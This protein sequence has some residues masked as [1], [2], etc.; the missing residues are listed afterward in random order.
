MPFLGAV[1]TCDYV[2]DS[3]YDFLQK[4]V[5]N[6]ICDHF[7]RKYVDKRCVRRIIKTL[8]TLYANRARNRR[9]V[10]RIARTRTPLGP[11]STYDL[12][13][14]SAF[15]LQYDLKQIAESSDSLSDTHCNLQ[16]KT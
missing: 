10:P 9:L 6:Y 14:D 5:S 2:Y 3:L 7:V 13:Y 12:V 11:V 16:S 15:D 1:Y 4:V 8:N